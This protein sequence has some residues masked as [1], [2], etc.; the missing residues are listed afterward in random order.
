[1][2][3]YI[4]V[5]MHGRRLRG[6]WGTVSRQ[7][8]EV[9]DGPCIYSSYISRRIVIRC[10]AKYELTKKKSQGEIYCREKEVFGPEKGHICYISDVRQL[11]QA[12]KTDRQNRVDD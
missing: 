11:R 12:K 3:I 8:F 5:C 4:Y 1:M 7:K 6:E 9:G 10:E 2:Y